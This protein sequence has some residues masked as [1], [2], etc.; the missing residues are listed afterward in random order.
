MYES[1]NSGFMS[2]PNK[3]KLKELKRREPGIRE[4]KIVF[5]F[6]F[7]PKVISVFKFLDYN[8]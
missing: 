2:S 4:G 8:L 3:V 6:F 7:K 1:E 5:V